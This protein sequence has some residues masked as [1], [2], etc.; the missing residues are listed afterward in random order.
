MSRRNNERAPA[1]LV[2]CSVPSLALLSHSGIHLC[3]DAFT[4]PWVCFG[5][6]CKKNKTKQNKK[7]Q[8]QHQLSSPLRSKCNCRA[9]LGRMTVELPG[10]NKDNRFVTTLGGENDQKMFLKLDSPLA[11]FRTSY[12]TDRHNQNLTTR[13][14]KANLE[15]RYSFLFILYVLDYNY[16]ILLFLN[17]DKHKDKQLYSFSGC[18]A[19]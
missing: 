13:S 3:I 11:S 2:S 16:L 18:R 8:S 17:P 9:S 4:N 5:R 12:P 7:K 19:D 6:T 15:V 10:G 14:G 1:Q